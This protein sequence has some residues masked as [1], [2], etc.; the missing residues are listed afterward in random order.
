MSDT[1]IIWEAPTI[2][3]P[4]FR[5]YYDD[6]GHV[7]FY[8]CEKPD[9]NFIVIDASTFAQGRPDVRVIDGKISTVSRGSI[10]SILVPGSSGTGCAFDDLSV[11]VDSAYTGMII[12][13]E[14]QTYEL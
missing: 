10:V 3:R 9:G 8:T 12:S 11:I 6:T 2:V 4:E 5:L 7:L 14:L 13:W 1:V